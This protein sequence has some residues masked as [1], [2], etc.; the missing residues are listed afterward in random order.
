[1]GDW[2][3]SVPL[4]CALLVWVASVQACGDDA[5]THT[6]A[7]AVAPDATTDGGTPS[8]VGRPD[9]GADAVDAGPVACRTDRACAA[10][11]RCATQ[12]VHEI[13]TEDDDRASCTPIDALIGS[14]PATWRW[15]TGGR[16]I[17]DRLCFAGGLA[18]GAGPSV[19]AL[20]ERQITLIGEAGVRLLRLDLPWAEIE[21]ERGVRDYSALD[22][23]VDRARDAGIEVL[24]ILAYGAPWASSDPA[25]DRF[26]P[27][28]DPADFAEF[29][30]ATAEHFDGRIARYEIWNEPN[31]GYRFWRP[32][33]HGDARAFGAL[34]GLATPAVREGCPDCTVMAGGFFFHEM[35]INGAV[36]FLHDLLAAAPEVLAPPPRGLDA[37]S[38]HPYPRYPPRVAPELDADGERA[39]GGMLDDLRAVL[40][41]HGIDDLPFA[42]TEVGWPSYGDVDE[43]TQADWLARSLLLG[44]ALG[45][46]PLCWFNV[47]DGPAHGRFPPEDDFGVYRF[48]SENG[49]ID[50]KPARDALAWLA[51]I[52]AGATFVGPADDTG[53]HA[54]DEGRF[55]LDFDAPDGRWTVAW[56]LDGTRYETHVAS[57][58]GVAHDVTGREIARAS[59]GEL[60]VE[61]SSSPVYWSD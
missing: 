15:T 59:G 10:S 2:H 56:T 16:A 19:D 24:G 41:L 34:V 32:T 18:R 11:E 44:A 13:E 28:D 54:P 47:A 21:P 25:A 38:F 27:P 22:P 39:M 55:A 43:A 7:A 46:D 29:A 50:P 37:L 42:M 61:V 4:R 57:D 51:R 6:D 35:I 20:R 52:G 5:R 30:R 48:D 45:M 14:A 17:A 23:M 40:A 3:P 53:L 36:E 26:Y 8:D 1:M 58:T 9:T 60:V 31:A 49:P 33:L 12:G